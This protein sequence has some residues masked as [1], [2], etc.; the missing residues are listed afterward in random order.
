MNLCYDLMYFDKE[1]QGGISKMWYE[2]FKFIPYS[3]LKVTFISSQYK[4]NFTKNF[5]EEKDYFN[6]PVI[7]SDR[8]INNKY[9]RKFKLSS[10][11]R[12]FKLNQIIPEKTEIFHSTDFVNPIRKSKNYKIIT[13]IHDMVFWDQKERF[14][15]NFSYY[16]RV[17]GIYNSLKVSDK[18]ITVSETSKKAIIKYYPWAEKKIIVNYHGL[19]KKYLDKKINFSKK[20][21]LLFIGGRNSYK[22]YDLLLEAF[23][24]LVKNFN[25]WKLIVVGEN[26][27]TIEDEKKIYE[28]LGILNNIHDMGLV[29]EEVL[30]KLL[31]E[32]SA[33]VI[34]SLNEGFNFPLLEGL[35]LG[36]PVLSSNIPVSK[37][38]GKNFVIYFENNKES[39]YKCL[40]NHVVKN[41]N[42]ID[43]QK[44][45]SYARSF[46]WENSFE[47]LI[48]IYESSI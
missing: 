27:H 8:R 35:T 4:Q 1:I 28:Q 23:S 29:S 45:Q 26:E 42:K 43:L 48:N 36:C 6:F 17:W 7:Y 12:S 44:A 22:N 2:Y 24:I 47:K 31:S 34:P 16:E 46:N 14:K 13:T 3:N 38:I 37:E 11:Y 9:I 19:N 20:K 40:E 15:K 21:Y 41:C 39:L 32:A 25:D 5:L 10:F 33:L 30:I 18:I